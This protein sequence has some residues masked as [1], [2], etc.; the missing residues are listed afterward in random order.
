MPQLPRKRQ[1]LEQYP[2]SGRDEIEKRIKACAT[3]IHSPYSWYR[4]DVRRLSI[5]CD[6]LYTENMQ[7]KDE[8]EE[9]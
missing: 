7:L 2:I 3:N 1:I 5:M 9:D 8:Q 6:F 4:E